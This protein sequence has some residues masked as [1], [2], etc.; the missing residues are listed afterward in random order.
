V[1]AQVKSHRGPLRDIVTDAVTLRD[2]A[3]PHD[4]I[5]ARD[6]GRDREREVAVA[7]TDS[8]PGHPPET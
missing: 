3:N 7:A 8:P 5:I 1:G 4:M 2:H 6:H